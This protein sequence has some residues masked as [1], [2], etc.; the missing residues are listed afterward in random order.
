[1]TATRWTLLILLALL[2][3]LAC[4]WFRPWTSY[5]PSLMTR[6]F[7]PE[8]RLENF[9]RMENIFPYRIIPASDQPYRFQRADGSL[10]AY[11]EHEGQLIATEAFLQRTHTTGLMV[12]D[13]GVNRFETYFL[14]AEHSDRFTSWSVAKT[15]VGTLTAIALKQ[16]HLQSLNDQVK[17]Y[18]SEL[19]GSAWG[20]VRIEDLLRMASGIE[21]SEI[22]DQRF[23]DINVLFYRTFLLGQPVRDVIRDRPAARPPGEA[24]HYISPNTQILAWVLEKAVQMPLTDYA[25]EALWQPLGMEDDALWSLDQ[26]GVELGFCCLNMTLRD[27]AKLGQLY[28]QQGVWRGEQLLPAGWTEQASRRPEPWLAAGHGFPERG[29]GYHLWVPKDPDEEYFFNGVWGQ[30]V[31]VS[32][33]HQVVVAKTSVDPLFREHMAEVISFM[34]AVSSHIA[35]HPAT[36]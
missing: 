4:W 12:L 10:P 31:W 13:Q 3:A 14:D 9:R 35:A 23:S 30:T 33:K 5:S 16:G 6:L 29:Y 24:F 2:V 36:P 8:H 32:D 11:F 20:E 1:M 26:S 28:L 19:D 34:R 22:Y 27:Y 21:F 7:H 18:V 25:S 17:Q 15:V